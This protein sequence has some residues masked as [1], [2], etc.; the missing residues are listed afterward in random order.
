MNK[1]KRWRHLGLFGVIPAIL[2]STKVLLAEPVT[3]TKLGAILPPIVINAENVSL[4][5]KVNVENENP[6]STFVT[7][8][9]ASGSVLQRNNLGY[10]IPWSGK[11]DELINNFSNQ[12]GNE[13]LIKILKEENMSNEMFPIRITVG[14]ET[15]SVL[16]FG[17]LELVKGQN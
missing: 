6:S 7:A 17:V 11:L 4:T 10:W 8:H 13:L 15:S 9:T 5:V 3:L 12:T 1:G 14:Y 16:K 2:L